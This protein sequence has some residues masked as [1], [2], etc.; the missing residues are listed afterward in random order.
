MKMT[1]IFETPAEFY[2]RT[3]IMSPE[4]LVTARTE[5]DEHMAE[6]R[7]KYNGKRD[8]G[9]KADALARRGEW[10]GKHRAPPTWKD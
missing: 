1:T 3:G 8:K 2:R 7:E 6:V 4:E 10:V 5:W 9:G